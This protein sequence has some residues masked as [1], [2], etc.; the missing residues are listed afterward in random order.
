MRIDET[1]TISCR[2]SAVWDRVRDPSIWPEV[3]EGVTRCDRVGTPCDGVGDRFSLRMR[4][5]P[6]E[7]GGIVEIVECVARRDL[8][9]TSITG[10]GQRGRWRLRE[11]E[12]GVTAVTLRLSYQS[13]GGIWGLLADRVSGP[14]VQ[15]ATRRTL[16]R[17]RGELE[18]APPPRSSLS[19]FETVGVALQ[20]LNALRILGATG[21]LRPSRPDRVVAAA[22]SLRQWG[23]TLPGAVAVNAARFPD[24]IASVSYTHLTLPTICSV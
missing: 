20:Q 21:L 12:P 5:G 15:S 13:P 17:L 1:I 19:P 4:V 23:F 14:Q 22:L 2:P 10:I 16:S 18:G 11:T 3:M 7:V 6:A 9:W 24:A 8:A